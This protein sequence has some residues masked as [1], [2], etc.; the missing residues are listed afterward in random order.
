MLTL[1]PDYPEELALIADAVYGSLL[2]AGFGR[3][4][5]TAAALDAAEEVRKRIGGAQIY[6]PM[7]QRLQATQRRMAVMAHL[8]LHPGD[9]LGAARRAGVA[10]NTA[11]RI[12]LQVRARGKK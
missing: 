8:S 10:E 12:E 7:G 1:E 3:D 2:R 5:C 6:I 4:H 9:Y 11:R